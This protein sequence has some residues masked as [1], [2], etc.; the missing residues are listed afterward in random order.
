[1]A[2][3]KISNQPAGKNKNTLIFQPHPPNNETID[4]LAYFQ[5]FTV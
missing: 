1:M 2:S 4:I 5:D 3:P